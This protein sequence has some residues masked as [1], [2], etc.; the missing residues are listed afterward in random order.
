MTGR[1]ELFTGP[2]YSGKTKAL[3]RILRCTKTPTVIKPDLVKR[4][5][6]SGLKAHDGEVWNGPVH[7]VPNLASGI[8]EFLERWGLGKVRG[9]LV[10]DEVHFFH[11]RNADYLQFLRDEGGMLIYVAGLDTDFRG[12]TWPITRRLYAIADEIIRLRGRC[13]VCGGPADMTQRLGLDGTPA[14]AGERQIVISDGSVRY[15]CRC[16]KCY[17]L[18]NNE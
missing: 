9:P 10:I 16:R 13:A 4:V 11:W 5:S 17:V 2:M 6:G 7:Y 12:K 8:R 14:K 18:A 1:I 15:E 3:V